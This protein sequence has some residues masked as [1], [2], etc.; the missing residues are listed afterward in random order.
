MGGTHHHRQHVRRAVVRDLPGLPHPRL[1]TLHGDV[2]VTADPPCPV[3][4]GAGYWDKLTGHPIYSK[5]PGPNAH[6]CPFCEGTGK[7]PKAQ[8]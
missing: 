6:R 5:P 8:V 7:T 4:E 3:C 2:V 1:W